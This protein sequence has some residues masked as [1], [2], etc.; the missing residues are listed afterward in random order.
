MGD[1]GVSVRRAA[2]GLALGAG[3]GL[4][5]GIVVGLDRLGEELLD[6][7]MQMLR[8]VPYPAVIFLFIIWF[9]IGETAKV[10]LIGLAT[11][12]PM[13]LNTSNG[14]RNVDRRVVEAARSFGLGGRQPGAPRHR[15]AG[16][17]VHHDRSA[18]LRRDLG[19]RPRLHRE[20][21]RQPGHRLPGRARPT[22]CN[23]SPSSSSAS[24]SM[25]SSASP[26]TSSSACWSGSPCRGDVT[27]PFDEQ[28]SRTSPAAVALEVAKSFGDRPSS[29]PWTSPSPTASSWRC[30]ARPAAGRPRCC[31]SWPGSKRPS[32]G[33][34]L[35]PEVRTVVYQE[36][37][38]V[39]SM[40]VWR[41]V[42]LGLP[43]AAATRAAAADA[44]A[45][46]R[47]RGSSRRLARHPLGWRGPAR[48]PGPGAGAR[49]AA[50][51]A[52]RALRRPRR[53]DPAQD[54]G[55]G[56]RPVRPPPARASCS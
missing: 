1:I 44:L 17:A 31:A 9:G 54:A 6:A 42:V 39:A 52:R 24:S 21:R 19:D 23:R 38:L 27:R 25:R 47:A 28:S 37:R 3:I 8:M 56:G 13:Y 33:E 49:A 41:N 18:L 22:A 20:H 46:G 29:T 50:P 45:R 12:F 2:L 15:P 53:A 35:V 32:T 34:V 43:R 48:G 30:S 5:L 26:P 7:P 16:H 51:P 55:P 14:V 4:V 11:L 36:P 40:R 10:L